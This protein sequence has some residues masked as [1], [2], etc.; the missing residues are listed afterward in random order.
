[1]ER[2]SSGPFT[3]KN[4]FSVVTPTSV[5]VLSSTLGRTA[6]CCDLLKR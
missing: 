6:S 1:M 2:L 5:R 4:G 3:S